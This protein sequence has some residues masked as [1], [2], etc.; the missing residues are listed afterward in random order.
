METVPTK[1]QTNIIRVIAIL[2]IINSHIDALVPIP[3]IS[4]GGSLG[5]ALF[6][7]LSGYGLTLSQKQNKLNWGKWIFKRIGK[8]YSTLFIFNLI[9]F[10]P[11]SI[12]INKTNFLNFKIII[13]TFLFPSGFVFIKALIV[14][15]II[16]YPIIKYF[17]S[18]ATKL[19]LLITLILHLVFYILTV[20]KSAFNI[21]SYENIPLLMLGWFSLFLFGICIAKD[22][23]LSR[24]KFNKFYLIA[25]F[26]SLIAIYGQRL[27]IYNDILGWA[28][29]I[30]QY[31][32]FLF[33]YTLIFSSKTIVIRSSK[34]SQL[35]QYLSSITLEIYLVHVTLLA[36]FKFELLKFP[37]GIF[38]L[39][40][41]TLIISAII[42]KIKEYFTKK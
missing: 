16:G 30:Q 22:E 26:G 13:D 2:L 1:E 23:I 42:N 34:L 21:F 35:I 38:T 36:T 11:L 29:I 25:L 19:V 7:I 28:Q 3:F 12:Y 8:L 10:I 33:C 31:L 17:S 32:L 27:L 37:L 40:T 20:D 18:R 4:T 5:N 24:T 39:I 9:F 6:F 14:F 15:Y 41:I